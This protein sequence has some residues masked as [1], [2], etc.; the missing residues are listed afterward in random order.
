MRF[1]TH[2]LLQ[3]AG[4]S[5]TWQQERLIFELVL[6]AGKKRV[7]FGRLPMLQFIFSWRTHT[8]LP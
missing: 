6:A 7:H 1:F 4:C 3:A 2:F 8:S 5:R